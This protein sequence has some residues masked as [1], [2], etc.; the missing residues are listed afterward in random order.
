MFRSRYP[1]QAGIFGNLERHRLRAREVAHPGSGDGC[2]AGTNIVRIA[3]GDVSAR[4][5]R[6]TIERY[7]RGRGDG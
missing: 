7:R 5:E 6:R 2:C 3:I 1:R 4:I